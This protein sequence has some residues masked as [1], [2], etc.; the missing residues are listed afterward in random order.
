MF[1]LTQYKNGGKI[2]SF[3]LNCHKWSLINAPS[4]N[5]GEKRSPFGLT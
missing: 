2:I 1:Y 4:L 3:I 5:K